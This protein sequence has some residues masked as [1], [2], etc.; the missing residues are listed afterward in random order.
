MCELIFSKITEIQVKLR[1]IWPFETNILAWQLASRVWSYDVF[2]V[3]PRLSADIMWRRRVS[4]ILYRYTTQQN[5]YTTSSVGP[6][7]ISCREWSVWIFPN[8]SINRAW[9]M[10]AKPKLSE[11]A[12]WK[13]LQ[14]YYNSN[15]AKININ[16]LFQDDPGRFDKFRYTLLTGI[17]ALSSFDL[18][19]TSFTLLS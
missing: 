11:E 17:G 10:E 3:I 18:D 4:E 15:G 14:E 6:S 16:Q 2:P 7:C 13:K 5:R 8:L 1:H 19:M 9:K 12:S